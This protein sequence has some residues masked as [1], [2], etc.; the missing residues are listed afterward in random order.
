[1]PSVASEQV[2]Q[3]GRGPVLLETMTYR[4]SGHSPSD[5]SSYRSKEEIERWQR[6]DSIRAFRSKL[7]THDVATEDALESAKA[8]IESAI[9]DALRLAVDFEVSPRITVD[10]E[11]VGEMM[12]SNQHVE[13]FDDRE[14]E[15]LQPLAD[16]PECSRFA[17]RF[18]RRHIEGQAG[19]ADEGFQRP[20]CDL[21][22]AAAPFRC[23]SR[24]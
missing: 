11:L 16:N 24:R 1:M 15:F 14:P 17:T 6:A 18:A 2:L 7:L 9:V 12:F 22:S 23:R 13:K 4:I 20:G 19:A 5:A 21:R 3:E 8:A 10:A